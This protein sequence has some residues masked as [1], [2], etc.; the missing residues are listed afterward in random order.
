MSYITLPYTELVIPAKNN[1]PRKIVR[2]PLL[3]TKLFYGK[4]ETMFDFSSLVD[5]GADFCIFPAKYGSILGLDVKKAQSIMTYGIGG[6]ETIYFHKVKI[7]VF[8]GNE[9][10]KFTV[11]AGFSYRMNIEGTGLLGRKG[12]FDQFKEIVFNQKKKMFRIME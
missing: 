11:K 7:G 3:N 6:Q 1:R 9:I 4:A 12:F 2:R 8:I 5:S 10:W